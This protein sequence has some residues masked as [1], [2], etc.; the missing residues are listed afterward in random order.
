MNWLLI[1]DEIDKR[2]NEITEKYK[3]AEIF[4]GKNKEQIEELRLSQ[5]DKFYCG[6][7]TR[8]LGRYA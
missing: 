5:I 6:P 1:S 4:K 7:W 3:T 2:I 8:T